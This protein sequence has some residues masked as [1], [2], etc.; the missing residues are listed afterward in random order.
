MKV[1]KVVRRWELV[2]PYLVLC[3]A[4]FFGFVRTEHQSADLTHE[5]QARTE[6]VCAQARH[7]Q[8]QWYAIAKRIDDSVRGNPEATPNQVTQTKD[9][10]DFIRANNK[11]V[12]SCPPPP[13]QG[14]K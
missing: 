8:A 14:V 1:V 9:F 13:I 3:A 6:Q 10:T 11:L 7:N 4:A 5:V 12:I 2:L